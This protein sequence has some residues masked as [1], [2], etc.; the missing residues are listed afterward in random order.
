[1]ITNKYLHLSE[2][3][4][5]YLDLA[6]DCYISE[7]KDAIEIKSH[8]NK[9]NAINKENINPKKT[10]IYLDT[11]GKKL[12]NIKSSVVD[13]NCLVDLIIFNFANK[14]PDCDYFE[15]NQEPKYVK[16]IENYKVN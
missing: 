8:K 4:S 11:K 12:F 13:I 2:E 5:K 7:L 15:Y 9:M 10:V 3:I 1:M 14:V 16:S 6:P